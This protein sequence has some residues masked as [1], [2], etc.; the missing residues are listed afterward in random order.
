MLL[1]ASKNGV[2]I[3]KQTAAMVRKKVTLPLWAGATE[4]WVQQKRTSK[5]ILTVQHALPKSAIFTLISQTSLHGSGLLEADPVDCMPK[6]CDKIIGKLWSLH[7]KPLHGNKESAPS[8]LY[9]KSMEFNHK[10]NCN[11]PSL[12]SDFVSPTSV[13]PRPLSPVPLLG[14]GEFILESWDSWPLHIAS[15]TVVGVGLWFTASGCVCAEAAFGAI[16]S[17][18]AVVCVST[19]ILSLL[20]GFCTFSVV[21]F[22]DIFSL[23]PCVFCTVSPWFKSTRKTFGYYHSSQYYIYFHQ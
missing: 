21:Q 1:V 17:L 23:S 8:Y 18:L 9:Q 3:N 7:N 19:A 4:H 12:A 5:G 22:V 16:S 2:V 10:L 15:S 14:D 6:I 13:R 11:S 20:L